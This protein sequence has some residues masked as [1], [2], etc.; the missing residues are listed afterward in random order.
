MPVSTTLPS[1]FPDSLFADTS[2]CFTRSFQR[3]EIIYAIGEQSRSIYFV[4]S[5]MVKITMLSEDGKE[6]ILSIRR[7][8]D[9]FGEF[10]LCRSACLVSAVAMEPSEVAEVRIEDLS[11][12]LVRSPDAAY[13]FLLWTVEKL[14]EA[15]ETIGEVSLDN[16]HRR[17]AKT[18]IRLAEKFGYDVETGTQLS[19]FITQEEIAQM[20]SAT[21]EA[22]SSSLKDLSRCG[23]ITYTRRGKLII[24][25]QKLINELKGCPT[26][27]ADYDSEIPRG[28]NASTASD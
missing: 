20:V 6:V 25:R 7:R 4:R 9:I 21:R 11:H 3:G 19:C 10:G 26:T 1:G 28:S 27:D 2:D 22:V 16:L 8:N 14:S 23:L 15:Y 13:Q 12:Q 24:H 17:L 18:L 5:G